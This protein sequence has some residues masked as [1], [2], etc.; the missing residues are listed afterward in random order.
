M[1]ELKIENNPFAKGFRDAGAGKREK[2]RQLHRMNGDATQSPP[3]KTA[4]LPTHSPHPSESNS[5]DDEPTLKK[6]KPEPSQTPTTSSLSTSTT[7]T[8]SAHHPLRSPQFCIPPPIDMM[9]QNMPMDLLAHWQMATLFPQFSM[10]LNS[11]AAAASLLSKHLAKASSE[12][13]VEATSEDSEE[14]EKPE[15]KKEQKSV[16]P[17]KKGGFDVL[18]LL[19]KP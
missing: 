7:P 2:K 3:G 1:T 12:C 15:V 18:D 4:S 13:K 14:A 5:E 17:P 9:Y 16:T 10:A 11:P 6:C 19:S 8:L